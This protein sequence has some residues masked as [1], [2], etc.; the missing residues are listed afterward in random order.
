[1]KRLSKVHLVSTF[2]IIITSVLLMSFVLL[3][4]AF[5]A[6]KDFNTSQMH[7]IK[8]GS[9]TQQEILDMFGKPLSKGLDD[10]G[11]FWGY[12]FRSLRPQKRKILKIW[13]D[14]NNIVK[15]FNFYEGADVNKRL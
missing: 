15:N 4:C 2:N 9:T 8:N 1:M 11:S 7:S 12:S 14:D 13:F 5:E 6:G 3:G 10:K